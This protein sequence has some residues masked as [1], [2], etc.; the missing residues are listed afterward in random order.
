MNYIVIMHSQ[1]NLIEEASKLIIKIYLLQHAKNKNSNNI[2]NNL[3]W[4]DVEWNIIS[5]LFPI[6]IACAKKYILVMTNALILLCIYYF[7]D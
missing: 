5:L 1:H 3:L 6:F 4:E 7:L 2:P